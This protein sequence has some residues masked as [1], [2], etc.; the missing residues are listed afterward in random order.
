MGWRRALVDEAVRVG[1]E[2][3]F[4][5]LLSGGVDLVGLSVVDLVWRHQADSEMVVFG[6]VPLEEP[7]AEGLGV[8]DGAEAFGELGL[9]F[10]GFEQAFREGIVVRGV[11]QAVA[12]GDAEIGERKGGGLGFDG[13]SSVGVRGE[14]ARQ[15]AMVVNS[16]AIVT[17]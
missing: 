13:R 16:L 12:F 11:G 7:A 9:I 4:E 1:V 15:D 17:P 5:G 2:G 8:L 10:A 3:Y 6:I 14:L